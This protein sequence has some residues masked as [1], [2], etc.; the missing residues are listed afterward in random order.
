MTITSFSIFFITEIIYRDSYTY[1]VVFINDNSWNSF[2]NYFP[3]Y[4]WFKFSVFLAGPLCQAN[5][6]ICGRIAAL[7]QRSKQTKPIRHV[8]MSTVKIIF[9]L[10][11]QKKTQ[12]A[13]SEKD[14]NTLTDNTRHK[15]RPKGKNCRVSKTL[16]AVIVLF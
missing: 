16:Q 3:K 11:I 8:F 6:V 9:P 12:A 2:V 1:L 5:L 15:P 14:L 13:Q 7:I 4:G 10:Q